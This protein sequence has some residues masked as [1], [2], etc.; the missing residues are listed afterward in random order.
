MYL[1]DLDRNECNSSNPMGIDYLERFL[2]SACGAIVVFA[3]PA[4][5]A[6]FF[7]GDCGAPVTRFLLYTPLTGVHF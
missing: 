5:R 3:A 7:G 4:A 1:I 6:R 2:D